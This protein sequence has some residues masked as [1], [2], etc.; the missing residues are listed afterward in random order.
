MTRSS[1]KGS[2][3]VDPTKL[4]PEGKLLLDH[5]TNEFKIMQIQFNQMFTKKDKDFNDLKDKVTDLLKFKEE[6]IGELKSKIVMLENKSRNFEMALDDQNQYERKDSVI[7]SG[8][9]LPDMSPN[10]NTHEIVKN[11]L[12]AHLNIKINSH[13]ICITHRLGPLRT[14]SNK[15]NIYVKFVR[16][17]LK[18]EVI[19]KSKLNK[20][21]KNLYANESLTPVR[22][23]MF[24]AL[25]QMKSRVPNLIKGCTTIEGK[26]YAFTPPADGAASGSRDRRHFIRDLQELREFCRTYVKESL[27]SFLQEQTSA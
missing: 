3:A 7:L 27:D 23:K 13:D 15:R 22:M 18:R 26:V 6:E 5:I 4:S 9:G 8:A 21:V 19:A 14:G 2:A 11:L 17:D 10:E 1:A 25:R 20:Q 12:D 24:R 16:R